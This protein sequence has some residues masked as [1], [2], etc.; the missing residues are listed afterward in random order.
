MSTAADERLEEERK[1][2]SALPIENLLLTREPIYCTAEQWPLIIDFHF[3]QFIR[4]I[5]KSKMFLRPLY[6]TAAWVARYIVAKRSY[7]NGTRLSC[8]SVAR[9]KDAKKSS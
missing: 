1:E 5:Q 3:S 6:Y 4:F 9:M 8:S 7:R 2:R